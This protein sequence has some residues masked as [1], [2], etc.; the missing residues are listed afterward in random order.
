M[1]R[2]CFRIR[3]Q[4]FEL[5]EKG[6]KTVEYRRDIPFWQKRIQ[7][8]M[9]DPDVSMKLKLGRAV[10]RAFPDDVQAVFI[11]GKRI[12]R[13]QAIAFAR[14]HTPKCFSDQ[15]KKDVDTETCLAFYLGSALDEKGGIA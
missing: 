14:Q 9:A 13:R 3:K 1:K 12:H 15:G 2:L 7:N 6:I 11:C 10:A 5:I 4:Y 8:I